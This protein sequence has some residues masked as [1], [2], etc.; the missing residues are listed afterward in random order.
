MMT[1]KYLWGLFYS[2]IWV[3]M[4]NRNYLYLLLGLFFLSLTIGTHE[5]LAIYMGTFF[6]ELTPFQ[7]GFL[8]LNNILGVHVGFFSPRDFIIG[9]TNAGRLRSPLLV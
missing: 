6:W 2:D 8:I 4:Q 3:V 5:T 1:A 7:I 9:S